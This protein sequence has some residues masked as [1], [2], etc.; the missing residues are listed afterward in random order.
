MSDTQTAPTSSQTE[1]L[2]TMKDVASLLNIPISCAY[3]LTRQG[4]LRSIRTGVHDKYVRVR[5]EDLE[6]Y[7]NRMNGLRAEG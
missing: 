7:K 3:D 5:P 4:K 2:L 1:K 6:V